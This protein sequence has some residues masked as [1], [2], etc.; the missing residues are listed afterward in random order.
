MLL[1]LSC[2]TMHHAIHGQRLLCKCNL[3]YCKTAGLQHQWPAKSG[4]KNLPPGHDRQAGCPHMQCMIARK[5]ISRVALQPK[6]K[7]QETMVCTQT[8]NVQQH[9]PMKDARHGTQCT[10]AVYVQ[11]WPSRAGNK[12]AVGPGC[13]PPML[14]EEKPLLY[15]NLQ[16]PLSCAKPDSLSFLS[17]SFPD[18]ANR[19]TVGCTK[20]KPLCRG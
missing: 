17:S 12:L 9:W 5:Q 8:H 4:H 7:T 18:S 1:L 11:T 14:P 6:T 10:S 20:D 2:W 16:V 19:E 15:T 3:L 13:R